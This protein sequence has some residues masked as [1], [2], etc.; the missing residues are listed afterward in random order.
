LTE[1]D[2]QEFISPHQSSA[3]HDWS[4]GVEMH[5]CA[6]AISLGCER[7]DDVCAELPIPERKLDLCD[8]RSHIA[9]IQLL[10]TLRISD[11]RQF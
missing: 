1:F 11:P 4:P 7:A 2:I 10:H 5:H 6:E 9:Q 3:T 8:V